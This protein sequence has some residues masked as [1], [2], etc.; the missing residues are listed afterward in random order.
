M[1][2]M[3]RSHTCV[4]SIHD[5]QG[6]SEL[7]GRSLSSWVCAGSTSVKWAVGRGGIHLFIH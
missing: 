1:C 4:H 2:S 7:L 3:F 5:L 6:Y